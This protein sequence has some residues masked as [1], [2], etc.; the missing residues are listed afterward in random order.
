[1]LLILDLDET[2]I[3]STTTRLDRA[4]DFEVGHYFVYCRPALDHFLRYASQHFEL[5]VWTSSSEAYARQ[6]VEVIFSDQMPLAFLWGRKRCTARFNPEIRADYWVKDLKKVKRLGY[7]LE[8]VIVID[9]SPEKLERQYG[10]H[11]RVEPFEGSV[12][13]R[14]LALLIRYLERI[15]AVENVR[16]VEKRS[17]KDQAR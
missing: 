11:L 1:M 10:N 17:W 4:P 6:V 7:P 8:Q 13:D 12:D 15:R 5:A 16:T 2:L 14:E 3:Y 9:D